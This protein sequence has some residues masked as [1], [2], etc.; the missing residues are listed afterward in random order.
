[1]NELEVSIEE[2][3]FECASSQYSKSDNISCYVDCESSLVNTDDMQIVLKDTKFI[4]QFIDYHLN[5]DILTILPIDFG[6]IRMDNESKIQFFDSTITEDSQVLSTVN[7]SILGNLV[8]HFNPINIFNNYGL[9]PISN[10]F[11]KITNFN[12]F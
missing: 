1:M 3:R 4:D 12:F 5:K 10:M 7:S 9:R 6:F 2:P 8:S 11:L